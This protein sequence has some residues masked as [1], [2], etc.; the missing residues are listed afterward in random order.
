MYYLLLFALLS[1]PFLYMQHS[2]TLYWTFWSK[3]KVEFLVWWLTATFSKDG[4]HGMLGIRIDFQWLAW[5][6]RSLGFGPWSTSSGKSRR[7]EKRGLS[8]T[9]LAKLAS[10]FL[11]TEISCSWEDFSEQ[12][13]SYW[14]ETCRSMQLGY[15][16]ARVAKESI[17][18]TLVK[19]SLK[20]PA[21][22]L[23]SHVAHVPCTLTE[24]LLQVSFQ[25]HPQSS[26][27]GLENMLWWA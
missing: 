20:S 16:A 7:G 13:A 8:S 27:P 12:I 17:W 25:T 24:S 19:A 11:N 14:V 1:C 6:S 10:S 23:C 15:F 5:Q 2:P 4:Q 9:T 26:R 22:L 18:S 21:H 3:E